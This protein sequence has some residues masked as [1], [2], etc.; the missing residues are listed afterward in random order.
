MFTCFLKPYP[1][2]AKFC[3]QDAN[4]QMRTLLGKLLPQ[5]CSQFT[6]Q[7]FLNFAHRDFFQQRFSTKMKTYILKKK[8]WHFSPKPTI[9]I[10]CRQQIEALESSEAAS[11][12]ALIYF[13]SFD[14]QP[15]LLPRT[16]PSF[17]LNL[18]CCQMK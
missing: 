14:F 18:K 17:G 15:I 12:E 9:S 7:H 1:N 4:L 16:I 5:I 8:E 13:S 11:Q 6:L 2:S 10:F 3:Q